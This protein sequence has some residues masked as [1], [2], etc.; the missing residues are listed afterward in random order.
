[1]AEPNAYGRSFAG[2]LWSAD[3]QYNDLLR[4]EELRVRAWDDSFNTQQEQYAY[5]A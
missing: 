4:A 5:I 2:A 3:M 1:M